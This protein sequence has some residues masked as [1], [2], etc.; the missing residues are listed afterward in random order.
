MA[1][2]GT[3]E[4]NDLTAPQSLVIGLTA[5]IL[6]LQQSEYVTVSLE[7]GL[8]RLVNQ[9]TGETRT[10]QESDVEAFTNWYSHN[11]SNYP[12]HTS[13]NLD[14]GVPTHAAYSGD[15]EI[16]E[17]PLKVYKDPIVL[18][19]GQQQNWDMDAQI[20]KDTK[21]Y[22]IDT[23]YG[24][25]VFEDKG[26]T[27]EFGR[28]YLDGKSININT[29]VFNNLNPAERRISGQFGTGIM[30]P[31]NSTT[32]PFVQVQTSDGR[33][34][35]MDYTYG[36]MSTVDDASDSIIYNENA[37]RFES[38]KTGYP[39]STKYVQKLYSSRRNPMS[40]D[41]ISTG[42]LSLND[43]MLGKVESSKQPKFNPV[44]GP[45]LPF[46]KDEKENGVYKVGIN[47]KVPPVEWNS[48]QENLKSA[49][50]AAIGAHADMTGERITFNFA[51]ARSNLKYLGTTSL[52]AYGLVN[53]YQTY[54]SDDVIKAGSIDV[55]I[56]YVNLKIG[57]HIIKTLDAVGIKNPAVY[58]VL[59]TGLG[60]IGD[61]VS[62]TT[63]NG[64]VVKGQ[65]K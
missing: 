14:F 57:A 1:K 32:S 36:D 44:S 46:Y 42:D 59:N 40:A 63:K 34:V 20:H 28:K 31:A 56:T 58:F 50:F 7:N 12:I 4:N 48:L 49:G 53:D 39:L 51:G 24:K 6:F 29:Y 11:S 37:K 47:I 23:A 21:I 43:Q 13:Y 41:F 8:M 9:S 22:H 62:G 19:T 52:L 18:P 38:I 2:L 35:T 64:L 3:K 16:N 15:G 55:G 65:D 5:A 60:F 30:V 26:G 27:D 10:I 33:I 45:P 25:Q 17:P 54:S 61:I